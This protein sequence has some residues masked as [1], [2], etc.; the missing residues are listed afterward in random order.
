MSDVSIA[1]PPAALRAAIAADLEPVRP[2]RSPMVRALS[3]APIA[4][5]LLLAA[6]VVFEF[7]DLRPLG[8]FLSWGVSL[9]QLAAGL[10]LAAAAL[11]EAVPG[12]AWSTTA[13]A[14]LM[15]GAV[16]FVIAVTLASWQ[17]SPVVL[18]RGWWE[19]W[20]ICLASSAVTALPAT[21]LTAVLALRA[22]PTRPVVTGLLAGVGAGLMA[23]AGWRL[24]CHFSEPAH[25][26]GAHLGGVLL[27]G[28]MGAILTPWLAASK[29]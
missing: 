3:L 28:S 29:K 25:V 17:A 20:A 16:V 26:L 5:A 9:I 7:R 24:F 10:G 4:L 22:L 11:R 18:G 6:P 14:G 15:T 1:R 2:L 23:D 21:I 12:R 8:W 19:I 13:I 27:A